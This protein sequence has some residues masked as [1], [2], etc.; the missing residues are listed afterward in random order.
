[1]EEPLL[2]PKKEEPQRRGKWN[3][4]IQEVKS[5]CLIA[6]P[7]IAVLFFQ[8]LLQIICITMVGHLGKLYLSSTSLAFSL[9]S[10][11]GFSFLMGLASG[12]E[13][14]SG[15]AYGVQQYQR[16]GKQTY[17]A[18]FSLILVSVTLSIVWFNGY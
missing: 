3:T 17:T 9:A 6:C 2:A 1:M 5:I 14:I 7:M 15:Q 4:F 18:I 12:L 16:V 13:T 8:Y 11:T 10:V